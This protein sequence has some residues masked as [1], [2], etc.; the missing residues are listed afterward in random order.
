MKDLLKLVAV[1][2]ALFAL[3]VALFHKKV[4]V[5]EERGQNRLEIYYMYNEGE[6]QEVWIE[7]A[8]ERFREFH[9]E[10]EVDVVY[11]G[12]EVL[13]KVRPRFIIG[14]P[15]DLVNQGGDILRTLAIDGLLEPLDD[16]LE[17][18]AFNGGIA[19]KDIFID[20]LVD[21]QR[22]AGRVYQVP[23]GLW[24][25]VIFYDKTMF[26]R[27][28]LEPP[29]TW[30]EFLE[31]CRVL[32]ENGIEPIASDGTEV[33]YNVSWYTA[34]IMRTTDPKHV[35]EVILGAPGTS[36]TEK[37]FV[38]AAKLVRELYDKEYIMKGY[39][40]S[41]WPSAQNRWAQGECGMLYCGTWIP[42]E[43]AEDLPE[44][45]RMGLFR[46]P[47]VEG[48]PDAGSMAQDIGGECFGVS[49]GAKNK[50]MAIEFLKFITRREE[51]QYH[52]KMETAPAT[53]GAAMPESLKDLEE[54]LLPPYVLVTGT[55]GSGNDIRDEWYRQVARDL[56]SDLWLGR[57][58][59]E[60]MGKLM[61]QRQERFQ[62]WLKRK[63][64][65]PLLV[66][67]GEADE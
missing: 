4:T 47:V 23:V 44:T 45:F 5:A 41:G 29:E 37:S 18:E 65:G 64:F 22:L 46:F 66:V 48:Y 6:A 43:M 50:K 42:K 7:G 38:D 58:D 63:G 25:S 59:P 34:M 56:W 3:A 13:G 8:V 10:L 53:K 67:K 30:S 32:K 39:E 36:W 14:N 28:G 57:V 20:G 49:R 24:S 26:E 55:S 2:L 9:P 51:F 33:G 16:A 52:D 62:E 15:P 17:T 61:D 60:E 19:W 31:V 11:A 27:F 21:V 35:R 54:L 12:R 1:L 40:G